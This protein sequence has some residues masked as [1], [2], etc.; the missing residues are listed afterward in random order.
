MPD[1]PVNFDDLALPIMPE[2][3]ETTARG[4]QKQGTKKQSTKDPEWVGLSTGA[5][6]SLRESGLNWLLTKG[7]VAEG[8]GASFFTLNK[9]AVFYQSCVVQHKQSKA[10]EKHQVLG[11]RSLY[12]SHAHCV[13]TGEILSVQVWRE[14]PLGHSSCVLLFCQRAQNTIARE[15]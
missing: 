12:S 11:G 1:D 8:F 14:H 9:S 3:R 4:K 7:T 10:A 13:Y 5:I 2:G 6:Q 15:Q